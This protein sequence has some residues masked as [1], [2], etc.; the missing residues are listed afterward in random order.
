[1]PEI[2]AGI[3]RLLNTYGPRLKDCRGDE[4][5]GIHV[6]TEEEGKI[7]RGFPLP[8]FRFLIKTLRNDR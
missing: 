8:L 6:F 4:E 3:Q 1:M 2:Q 5:V 7:H